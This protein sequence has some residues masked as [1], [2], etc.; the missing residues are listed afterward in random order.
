MKTIRKLHKQIKTI[1]RTER[2]GKNRSGRFETANYNNQQTRNLQLIHSNPSQCSRDEK[3]TRNAQ[4]TNQNITAK[5]E[6]KTQQTQSIPRTQ[7]T[8]TKF[9]RN[10][11]TES[12]L[13]KFN[14]ANNEHT[15]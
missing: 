6:K 2:S 5:H 12:Q 8:Q 4:A 1:R 15:Q 10:A 14:S 11:E 3:K 9:S 7:Q 13:G